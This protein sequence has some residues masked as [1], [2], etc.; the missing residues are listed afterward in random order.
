MLFRAVYAVVEFTEEKEVA[1]VPV[2]WMLGKY[3][4]LWPPWKSMTKVNRAVEQQQEP[5]STFP[6]LPIR[7]FMKQVR[8]LI[9]QR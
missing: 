8:R 6:V 9:T 3:R 1:I 4:S 7:V 2:K 5:D